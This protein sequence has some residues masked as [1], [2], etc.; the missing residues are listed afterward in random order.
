L[1]ALNPFECGKK[2]KITSDRKGGIE[3]PPSRVDEKL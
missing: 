1:D 3:F 2:A